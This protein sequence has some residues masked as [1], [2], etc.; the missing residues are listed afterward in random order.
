MSGKPDQT[1]AAFAVACLGIALYAVMDG[2]MKAVSIQIGAYNALFWRIGAAAVMTGALYAASRPVLPNSATMKVHFARSILVAIMAMGFFWGIVRVPLAE[3]IALSFIA[4]LIALALAAIFLKEQVGRRSVL[5]SVLGLA[6]V[7]VIL[8]GRI[9]GTHTDETLWGIAAVLLAAV[10]YAANLVVARHQA[11]IARPLEIT[12]FQS[13]F[14]L[15]ILALAAPFLLEV[16]GAAHWPGLGGAALLGVVSLLL[17]SWAYARAEAQVLLT[18]EYTA[19]IWA[20]L[21]GWW[22][23]GEALT[24][25]TIAGTILIVAGCLLALRR[26]PQIQEPTLP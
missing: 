10:F 20:S 6:G 23:F 26:A 3:A 15:G 17:L 9:G 24:L 22:I 11:Q 13:L 7:A 5:G 12:F 21:M 2:V 25:T 19:F 18:V 14:V 1:V 8:S 4:P 16:P